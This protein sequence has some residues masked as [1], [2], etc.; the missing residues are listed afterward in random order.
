MTHF[1]Y[2]KVSEIH[3]NAVLLKLSLNTKH[4]RRNRRQ[5]KLFGR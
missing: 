3:Q 2:P 5:I 4:E 1:I